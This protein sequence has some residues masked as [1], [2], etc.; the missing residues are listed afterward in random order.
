MDGF[1]QI[2]TLCKHRKKIILSFVHII[3]LYSFKGQNST[4]YLTKNAGACRVTK[5]FVH[6]RILLLVDLN[7]SH[8]LC[9]L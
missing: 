3:N 9:M 5:L 8:R 2:D 1:I 6:T 7:R 4:L